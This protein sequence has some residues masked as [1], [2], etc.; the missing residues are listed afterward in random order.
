MTDRSVESS[1]A[2]RIAIFVA[3]SAALVR[4]IPLQWLHPLT[5]AE[6]EFYRA[7]RWIAEGKVPFRDFWEHHTPLAWFLFA[8]FSRLTESPGADAINTMRWAQ[9]PGWVATFWLLN[10]W[11]RDA[12]A[13]RFARWA[14]MAVALCSSLFM[15][16]AVEYRV[17][18]LG[19]LLFVLGLVLVQRNRDFAAGLVFCL[20]G[21]TNLRLGPVLVVAVLLLFRWKIVAGGIVALAA[22]LAPFAAWGALDELWQ[23][24][25]LDNLGERF[26]TPVIGGFLHRLLVPFGVRIMASDRFFEWGAVD[27]GGIA[28]L[29]LGFVGL[30]LVL[31][32]RP[33]AGGERIARRRDPFF[34]VAILQA[35][36]LLFIAAMKFIYNYHF[37][38][39]VILAVPL[40][41]WLFHRWGRR[42]LIA[43][44]LML[45][46]G[47]SAFGSIFRGKEQDLAY[48]DRIM[49]EVHART[50]AGDEVWSGVPWALRREPAYRFWFLPELARQLVRQGLAPRYSM[51]DPPAAIVF[52]HY[53]LVWVGTVQR[54]L[55]THLV[56]H[57]IPVWRNLWMPAMNANVRPGTGFGWIVPRD[58]QY[59]LHAS[60]ELAGHPWFRDPLGVAAYKGA[61]AARLTVELP[62]GG[63]PAISLFVDDQLVAADLL[64]LRLRQGQRVTAFNTDRREIAVILLSTLHS[65]DDRALFRQPPAGVSLEAEATRVT[66]VPDF[67]A[68]RR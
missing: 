3:S 29:L 59:R 16:P 56:R 43:G 54:E 60:A 36:N 20:A 55:A 5:W 38:L 35:A 37:A 34:L 25:W 33:A 13:E 48:Q 41:A 2:L 46:L 9:I 64:P 57:Y 44:F 4:L 12:G 18:S 8:P 49:R 31:I 21:F 14:A 7:T 61:D 27:A 52:D 67:G 40:M 51:T 15:I 28:V 1:A 30:L 53:A 65:T 50:E 68:R 22:L 23:Q 58:G 42:G 11:M 6:L 24:V 66:H 63:S 62:K 47:V 17:E 10:V 19:C 45:A 32:R 39:T 26:A